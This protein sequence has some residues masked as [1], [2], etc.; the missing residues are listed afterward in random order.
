MRQNTPAHA[1]IRQDT[2]EYSSWNQRPNPLVY[3][4]VMNI[5]QRRPHVLRHE[6]LGRIV[7]TPLRPEKGRRFNLTMFDIEGIDTCGHTFTRISLKNTGLPRFCV[8]TLLNVYGA[9]QRTAHGGILFVAIRV[10]S[11]RHR[12]YMTVC[13]MVATTSSKNLPDRF[14]CGG[15]HASGILL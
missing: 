13:R 9:S 4:H 10:T 7:L 3:P 15:A 14:R 8:S 12:Q 1:R 11:V 2:P 5:I 6:A